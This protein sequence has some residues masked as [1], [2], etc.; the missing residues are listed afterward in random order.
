MSINCIYV[1]FVCSKF[2]DVARHQVITMY[3]T[4]GT[5]FEYVFIMYVHTKS[6]IPRYN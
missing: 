1:E 4:F 3:S 6:L 2:S 5:Q